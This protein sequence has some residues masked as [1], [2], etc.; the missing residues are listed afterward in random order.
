[1]LSITDFKTN[2]SVM[3]TTDKAVYRHA[4]EVGIQSAMF[5][6]QKGVPLKLKLKFSTV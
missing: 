1:M 6:K 2:T 5:V 4:H 3:T